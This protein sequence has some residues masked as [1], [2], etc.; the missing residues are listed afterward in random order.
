[1]FAWSV[2]SGFTP[3]KRLGCLYPE[4]TDDRF[5]L[6]LHEP[7]PEESADAVMQVLQECGATVDGRAKRGGTDVRS[8]TCGNLLLL[9]VVVATAALCWFVQE[10]DVSQPNYDFLPGSRRWSTRRRTT[11]SHQSELFG[12]AR[13]SAVPPAGTIARGQLPLHY[14]PTLQDALR[15]GRELRNPFS[16]TDMSRRERGGFVLR[17]VLSGLPR[18]VGPGEWSGYATR[19]SA[20]GLA[21]GGPGTPNEGRPNV[22]RADLRAREYACIQRHAF[23]RGPLERHFARPPA[24]RAYHSGLCSVAFSGSGQVV[25][26][27]TVRPATEPTGPATTFGTCCP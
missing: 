12:T 9:L 2:R 6:V 16:E 5:V 10:R 26:K 17:A 21:A 7:S 14:Q 3:E 4:S 24:A 20:A 13:R 25:R 18:S 15:A 22:P 11:R 8:R 1:M 19:I 23:A 27:K